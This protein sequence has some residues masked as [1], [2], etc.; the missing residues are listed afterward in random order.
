[1]RNDDADEPGG[2][3]K[4]DK[5]EQDEASRKQ[6]GQKKKSSDASG[7]LKQ[8]P[9]TGFAER[10]KETTVSKKEPVRFATRKKERKCKPLN[11]TKENV[12]RRER[13]KT[14]TATTRRAKGK[15]N[16][17]A[18][19]LRATNKRKRTASEATPEIHRSHDNKGGGGK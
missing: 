1:M 11:V 15:D 4:E 16:E 14:A 6:G 17:P 10:E 5:A 2:V 9:R 13:P 7:L 3:T 18:G 19:P 12:S 8:K